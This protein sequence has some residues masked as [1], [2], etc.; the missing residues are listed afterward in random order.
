MGRP[1]ACSLSFTVYRKAD[2]K[3]FTV[4]G[5]VDKKSKTGVS[6]QFLNPYF[7]EHGAFKFDKKWISL[8]S[9]ETNAKQK[10]TDI[11]NKVMSFVGTTKTKQIK[12][13]TTRRRQKYDYSHV[14]FNSPIKPSLFVRKGIT[15][16]HIVSTFLNHEDER[17]KSGEITY[18]TSAS[19]KGYAKEIGRFFKDRPPEMFTTD[20][21][22]KH[23]DIIKSQHTRTAQI[24]AKVYE[25]MLFVAKAK[26]LVDF[27]VT[28]PALDLLKIKHIVQRSRCDE[29]SY[30][31]IQ[32][33]YTNNEVVYKLANELGLV[34][35]VR[36]MDLVL[37][38]N[39]KGSDWEK[40]VKHYEEDNNLGL[41]RRLKRSDYKNFAPYSYV[42]DDNQ[43]LVVYQLKT[44]NIIRIPYS[45][46]IGKGYSTVGE[47]IEKI[48]LICDKKSDY[49]LHH[50]K[51]I[52]MAKIGAPIHPNTLSRKFTE[53]VRNL[54]FD[55]LNKTPPT[56][57]ELRSLSIR[58]EDEY[59]E[60]RL[61]AE[62]PHKKSKDNNFDKA[63]NSSSTLS[64]LV[65]NSP[66]AKQSTSIAAGHSSNAVTSIYRSCRGIAGSLIKGAMK[67]V[68]NP[69]ISATT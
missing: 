14:V 13:P 16:N 49:L 69:R 29:D 40:R 9:S 25:R 46:K 21:I 38:R 52:G 65:T 66:S 56:W 31:H 7:G 43:E 42:D 32:N 63:R 45:H 54:G 28:N 68:A 22:T 18:T 50:I 5:K 53:K 23:I 27:R 10:A 15:T 58:I 57:H 48:K 67:R 41:K 11:V 61:T 8:G 64:S 36:E 1:I 33:S 51:R 26:G 6:F 47:V 4:N 35:K 37:I 39:K 34:T 19:N 55:W 30:N 20:N 24:F 3:K 2:N 59:R 12:R 17:A 62:T 60:L 44:S